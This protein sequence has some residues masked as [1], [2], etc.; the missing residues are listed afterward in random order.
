MKIPPTFTLLAGQFI[1]M[2][3][4][5]PL[6]AQQKPGRVASELPLF[7]AITGKRIET[8][9]LVPQ[10]GAPALQGSAQSFGQPVLGGLWFQV[11]GGAEYGP[12]KWGFRWM[13]RFR[14]QGD[15]NAVYALYLDTMGQQVQYQGVYDE[16]A[17]TIELQATLPDGGTSQNTLVLNADGSVTINSITRDPQG[18]EAVRYS[19]KSV[20]NP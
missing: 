11:D 7:K 2:A 12:A 20:A 4:T 17:G 13:F 8:G 14:E 19:A 9:T 5:A 3:F 10:A 1:L 6:V 15:K 16:A 18:N